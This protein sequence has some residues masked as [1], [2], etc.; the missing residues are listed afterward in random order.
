[1]SHCQHE[2]RSGRWTSGGVCLVAV[3]ALAGLAACG[4]DDGDS[5]PPDW[6]V[7]TVVSWVD[8]GLLAEVEAPYGTLRILR[9]QG[10]HFEMGYQYGYLMSGDV[11]AIWD[12]LFGPLIAE[13]LGLPVDLAIDMFCTLMDLAWDHVLPH[14]PQEYLDEL[15][16]VIDGASAAGH[17]DPAAV[18]DIIRRI[19]MLV[20]TSQS[21]SFGGEV[22][23][24]NRFYTRGFSTGAEEYYAQAGLDG[25][26]LGS[27]Q[28]QAMDGRYLPALF[29]HRL[30]QL[31]PMTTCSFFAVW[32]DRTDGRQIASR[33]LDWSADM[34]LGRFGLIT[35][36]V[37]D[38]GVAHVTVGYV[39]MI[40][41]LSGMSQAGL[42]LGAVGSGSVLER[43]ATGS[44]GMRGREFLERAESLEQALPYLTGEVGDGK[45]RAPS[46]GTNVM[47][48]FGDP[49][50]GGVAAEGAVSEF[51]GIF[52]SLFLYGAFSDCSESAF[53]YEFA[54]DGTLAGSWSHVDD[55][56]R[57]NLESEAYE[58]DVDGNTRTFEVDI[59][60]DFVRDAT[61]GLID[62]PSGEP[63]PV[64]YPLPCALF[65]SGEAM[66]H[67]IRR[68]QTGSNSPNDDDG[69]RLMHLD[70]SYYEMFIAQGEMIDAYYHGTSFEFEGDELIP[71]NGGER[72]L[73]GPEE[74][75]E[76]IRLAA[77]NSNVYSVIYDTTNLVMWVA[78]ES[79]E[80]AT[81][82]RA[83]DNEYFRLDLADLLPASLGQ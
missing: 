9:L 4:D 15:D 14:M 32:G 40:S 16:G 81:W 36:F 34:G 3:L 7:G 50:G 8:D 83:A 38:D 13:E 59:N 71:D 52:A 54:Q 10:T 21:E 76:I 17:P 5:G 66:A 29:R 31:S 74:A 45:S 55:A 61:G 24:M 35:V 23:E 22:G 37:P 69:Y 30:A 77:M 48:A 57:V 49:S 64:A 79:G 19:M 6:T 27:D 11:Q 47:L 46:I 12:E 39:G 28:R 25:D 33:V 44:L 1:M 65:R 78:Y 70:G 58:I 62:D 67:G 42:A 26:P 72:V 43:L 56:S 51:N 18:A 2:R 63:Y 60:G 82:T 20:D 80:G 68:W 53:L 73:I 75:Q 41:A